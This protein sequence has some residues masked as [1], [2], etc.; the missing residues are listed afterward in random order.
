MG[1]PRK[2]ER[3]SHTSEVKSVE[4][5]TT[6]KNGRRIKRKRKN[7]KGLCAWFLRRMLVPP[8]GGDLTGKGAGLGRA[9]LRRTTPLL[10]G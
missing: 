6:L 10:Q 5:V 8:A 7:A 1:S 2:E 9:A 4:Q 3:M